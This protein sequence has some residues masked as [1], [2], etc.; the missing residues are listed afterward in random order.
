MAP[1][2]GEPVLI[3]EAFDLLDADGERLNT[4]CTF[5]LM[6][7]IFVCFRSLRWLV[8]PLVVVQLTLALTRGLLVALHLQL[9][10]V[11]SMLSAI[12]TVVGVATVM[13]VIVRFR[14]A[15]EQ[16]LRSRRRAA[17]GEPTPHRPRHLC[18]FNRRRR[19]SP[20]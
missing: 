20:R 13:H 15:Q 19:F 7:T 5:L 14:D 4:W 11:S 12:V 8:L 2:S 3:E 16:G 10:M 17:Q 9:S 6:L 18:L 1:W